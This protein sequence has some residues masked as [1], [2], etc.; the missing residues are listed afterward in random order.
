L[1]PEAVAGKKQIAGRITAYVCRERVC[2]PP[3][4]SLD[5]L[6]ATLDAHE[7]RINEPRATAE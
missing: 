3:I 1:L 2:S 4:T 7:H 5:E 6:K